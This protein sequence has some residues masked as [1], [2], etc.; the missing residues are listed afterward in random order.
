VN[1][2]VLNITT[3]ARRLW[4][5]IWEA[6]FTITVDAGKLRV[7]PRSW[8]VPPEFIVPVLTEELI[9]MIREHLKGLVAIVQ[10]RAEED[11]AYTEE[12]N[13]LAP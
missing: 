1:T 11:V 4:T 5:Q 9:N 12:L 7:R 6:G 10:E 13:R 2:S 8:M 3:A